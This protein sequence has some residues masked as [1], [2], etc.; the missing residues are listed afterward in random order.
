MIR[1]EYFRRLVDAAHV[2]LYLS[3][4]DGAR[5]YWPWRMQPPSEA[6]DTYRNACEQYV[7]DSDPTEDDVTTAD[8]LS[9]AAALD[10]EVASLADVYQDKDATVDALLRG[11]EV[12][13]DHRFDGTLLLPLQQ[14]YVECYREIGEPTDHWIGLGGLKGGS[15]HARIQSATRFRTHT[16]PNLHLHGFGW[17]PRDGLG[18]AI[19]DDPALLDSLDYSTPMQTMVAGVAPGDERMSVQAAYASA[20]LIQDLRRV[21]PHPDDEPD[22]TAQTTASDFA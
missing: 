10:A 16:D 22:T 19:R 9:C 17:G 4:N 7:I 6:S 13:D 1:D 8:V 15:A 21:T 20:R 18:A 12:A 2:D 11:L 3:A 14:P 5:I